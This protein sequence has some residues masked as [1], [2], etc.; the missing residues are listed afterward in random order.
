MFCFVSIVMLSFVMSI[1]DAKT[2]L[3][4]VNTIFISLSSLSLFAEEI[5]K[6]TNRAMRHRITILLKILFGNLISRLL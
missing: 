1:T 2:T 6:N 5:D 3:P 4:L